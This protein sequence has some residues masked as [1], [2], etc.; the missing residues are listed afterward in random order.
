VL[1][2][3]LHERRGGI[4]KVQ[5]ISEETHGVDPRVVVITRGGIVTEEDRVTPGKTKEES[6]VRRVVEKT[7]EFDPKK[8]KQEFEEA[9]KDIGRD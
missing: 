8:E 1:L 4:P 6:R 9:R 7:Q 2:T 3:K 5:L